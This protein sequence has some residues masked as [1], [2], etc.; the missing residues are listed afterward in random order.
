MQIRVQGIATLE[1]AIAMA[2]RIGGLREMQ[3]GAAF[4]PPAAASSSSAPGSAPMD[5]DALNAMGL[6]NVEGLEAETA[7]AAPAVSDVAALRNEMRQMLNAMREE[8]RSN[9]R[10]GGAGS[11]SSRPPR[12]LPR[13]P[14]LTPEQVKEY[15]DAGKCF[16][17]GSTEHSARG[18][19]KRKAVFGKQKN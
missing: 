15:M 13:V 4:A 7:S 16:G 3:A 10:G 8:R 6:E 19:P 5:L 2:T 11:A 18:C 1:Q 17:C 14:H 9:N 12:S